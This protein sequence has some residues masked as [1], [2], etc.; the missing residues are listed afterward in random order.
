MLTLVSA[1][2][3]LRTVRAGLTT[4]TAAEADSG[5]L[6]AVSGRCASAE[7]ASLTVPLTLAGAPAVDRLSPH[8]SQNAFS[9][10]FWMPQLVQATIGRSVRPQRPQNRANALFSKAQPQHVTVTAY[11]IDRQPDE[12]VAHLLTAEMRLRELPAVTHQRRTACRRLRRRSQRGL[13]TGDPHVSDPPRRR[14]ARWAKATDTPTIRFADPDAAV[15]PY[16]EMGAS[17]GV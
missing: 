8:E 2:V 13:A 6:I 7:A 17:L 11:R 15:R 3:S 14:Y 10:R 12:Q 9:A 5:L 4:A 1:V 16:C